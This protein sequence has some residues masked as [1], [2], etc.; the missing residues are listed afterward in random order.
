MS[1]PVALLTNEAS[2]PPIRQWYVDNNGMVLVTSDWSLTEFSNA[3]TLKARTKQLTPKQVKAVQKTL[4][5]FIG[6]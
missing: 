1:A 2:A 5:F 4:E 6:G 3:L